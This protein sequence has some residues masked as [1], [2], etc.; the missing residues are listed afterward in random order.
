MPKQCDSS[1][2]V[3]IETP[4]AAMRAGVGELQESATILK[5][6]IDE[7]AIHVLDLVDDDRLVLYGPTPDCVHSVSL[8]AGSHP[9]RPLCGE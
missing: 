9:S 1:F 5:V 6:A 4:H 3:T 8:V 7:L 2:S